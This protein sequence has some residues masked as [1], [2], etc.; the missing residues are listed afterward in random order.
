MRLGVLGVL[1]ALGFTGSTGSDWDAHHQ[2]CREAQY[3]QCS[4]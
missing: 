3:S 2:S 1:G 4:Q